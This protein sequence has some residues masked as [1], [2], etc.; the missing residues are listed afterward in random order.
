MAETT[1]QNK[2]KVNFDSLKPFEVLSNQFQHL[3][4]TFNNAIVLQ[5]SNPAYFP[6]QGKMIIIGNPRPGWLEINF[7]HPVSA[8][9]IR[10]T[11]SQRTIISAHGDNERLLE[12]QEIATANLA[13][14]ETDIPANY[15]ISLV[16][17]QIRKVT[18]YAFDGQVTV[19]ELSF[20]P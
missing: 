20:Q 15:P 14:S 3:G 6:I 8:V 17:P 19:S 12:K 10:L 11:A 16:A 2:T 9:E 18:L 4:V 1:S 5:P 7:H 13:G